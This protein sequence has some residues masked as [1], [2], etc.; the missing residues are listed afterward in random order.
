M[1]LIIH[2]GDKEF[3]KSIRDKLL[4]VGEEADIITD[5]G[6]IKN[7]IGCFGCWVKTPGRCVLQDSYNEMGKLMG[8]SSEL[9]IISSGIYGTYSPFVRNVLDRSLSYIH[10]YFTK[11]ENEIHHKVRYQNR[12]LINV[13]FYGDINEEEKKTAERTV[14]ANVLNFNSILGKIEFFN[15]KEEVVNENS[16]N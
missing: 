14:R 8:N 5:D 7:C 10:P 9:I 2:D 16:I 6:T 1:K 4:G 15:T 13:F 12:L 3:E 11:R